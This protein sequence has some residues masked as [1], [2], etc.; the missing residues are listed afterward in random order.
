MVSG[1]C[2][3]P[4]A[5]PAADRHPT[6]RGPA[7]RG[8]R[9]GRSANRTASTC[10]HR[11]GA[12]AHPVRVEPLAPIR[13]G[14]AL[15]DADPPALYQTSVSLSSH[16]WGNPTSG[17][18]SDAGGP[19]AGPGG[20]VPRIPDRT[21]L[22]A[23]GACL[24]SD[25][26][27]TRCPRSDQRHRADPRHRYWGRLRLGQTDGGAGAGPRVSVDLARGRPRAIHPTMGYSTG[28][29]TMV[30]R[31]GFTATTMTTGWRSSPPTGSDGGW[32][33]VCR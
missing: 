2:R 11:G 9:V 1:R 25:W 15:P 23:A 21:A 30:A 18:A 12:W 20:R 29:S 19:V 28:W 6:G 32:T 17:R 4:R 22:R 16:S 7:R 5:A 10:H 3:D 24:G 8:G 31:S 33:P 14:G 26:R 13:A 27:S